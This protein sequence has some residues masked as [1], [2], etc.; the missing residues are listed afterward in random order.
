MRF[1]IPFILISFVVSAQKYT[2]PDEMK[3]FNITVNYDDYTV[4]TQMLKDGEKVKTDNELAYLWYKSNK[5]IETKGGYDG[6]L[7]HGYY[8]TFYLNNQ[9]KE[10]GEIK[11]G[12]KHKEWKYWYSNGQLREV[13]TWKQGRKYGTYM[14]YNEYGKLMAKGSF[15]NDLLNGEF[16]T[17]DVMGNKADVKKYKNGIEVPPKVKKQK[18]EKQKKTEKKTEEGN[19]NPKDESVKTEKKTFGQKIKGLFKKK[20]KKDKPK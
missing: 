20:E 4:K 14:L 18:T 6:R 17:Y 10:Q 11:Y 3:T 5:I 8:K 12:L 13:I 1:L 16:C 2:E 19:S 7:L 15:K 9:L